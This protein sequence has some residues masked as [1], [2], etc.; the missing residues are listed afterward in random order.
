MCATDTSYKE[1]GPAPASKVCRPSGGG[2]SEVHTSSIQP[3]AIM[4]LILRPILQHVSFPEGRERERYSSSPFHIDIFHA[5]VC[6]EAF[7]T[8]VPFGM[9]HEKFGRIEIGYM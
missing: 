4:A 7:V 9:P 2:L 1:P 5:A 8:I 6:S 3:S